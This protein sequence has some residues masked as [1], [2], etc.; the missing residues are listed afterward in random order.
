MVKLSSDTKAVLR[1]LRRHNR[2]VE[3]ELGRLASAL[4]ETSFALLDA[5]ENA[6]YELVFR[7]TP[8]EDRPEG[9]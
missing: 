8:R 5:G 4:V 2:A 3:A 1:E 7:R 9:E 6:K